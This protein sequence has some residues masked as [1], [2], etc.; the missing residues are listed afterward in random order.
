MASIYVASTG[1]GL[2]VQLGTHKVVF[3]DGLNSLDIRREEVSDL[4]SVRSH[5]D[6]WVL[7]GS[8]S[9]VASIDPAGGPVFAL[10]G[11]AG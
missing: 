9:V 1:K 10:F 7:Q 2:Y 11:R 3:D 4:V 5:C 6:G 8:A